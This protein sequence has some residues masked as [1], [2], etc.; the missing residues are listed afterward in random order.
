[1]S[2]DDKVV[3]FRVVKPDPTDDAITVQQLLQEVM[4]DHA[5][6]P[7]K[8]I[9]VVGFTEEGNLYKHFNVDVPHIYYLL[10]MLLHRIQRWAAF[11]DD[12]F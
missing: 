6:E 11:D 10:S 2:S 5:K 7:F 8:E 3:P 9:V 4:D 1:M 12:E